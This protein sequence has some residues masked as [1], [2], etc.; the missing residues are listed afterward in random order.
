MTACQ[1]GRVGHILGSHN[2]YYG[3]LLNFHDGT[4]VNPNSLKEKFDSIGA[5]DEKP[6][7]VSCGGVGP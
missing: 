7:I 1:C 4:F 3:N 2:V 6:A 5:L